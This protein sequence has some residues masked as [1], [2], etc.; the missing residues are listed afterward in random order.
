VLAALVQH[1][2]FELAEQRPVRPQR[3]G[4]TVAPAGGIKMTVRGRRQQPAP[5]A[6]NA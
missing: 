1:Y 2:E 6:V 4:V 3:R 5:Q